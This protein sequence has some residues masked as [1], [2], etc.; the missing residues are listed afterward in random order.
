M[1]SLKHSVFWKLITLFIVITLPVLVIGITAMALSSKKLEKEIYQ[2]VQASADNFAAALDEE[3]EALFHSAYTIYSATKL[4]WYSLSDSL[5]SPYDREQNF[6]QIVTFITNLRNSNSCVRNIRVYISPLLRAANAEGTGMGSSSPISQEEFDH[7][8]S[9]LPDKNF[10]QY[11][12][13]RIFWLQTNAPRAPENIIEVE[14]DKNRLK[15][16]LQSSVA[17][18]ENYYALYTQ[19]KD[20]ALTNIEDP[21]LMEA[22]RLNDMPDPSLKPVR[23]NLSGK[24]YTVF[25]SHLD[26][27]DSTYI[28]AVPYTRLMYQ[29]RLTA[30]LTAGFLLAMFAGT[31]LFLSGVRFYVHKPLSNLISAFS[32]IGSGDLDVR[33]TETA[34]TE[35]SR[36]Y[37]EFN[38]M[39]SRLNTLI[40]Q[41]SQQKILLQ[42]AE[43]KQLQAQ[44][45]PHFLYNSFFMLQRTI[46]YD[47]REEAEMLAEELG[48]YF[49][50]VTRDKQDTVLL[51]QEY[52][53]AR[54]YCHIQQ[55]RFAGRID[56]TLQALP[57]AFLNLPV[58]KFILQPILE[59]S[60]THGLE[61]KMSDGLLV[62]SFQALGNRLV[63][64]IED[65]GEELTEDRL[66]MMQRKIEHCGMN[67]SGQEITGILNVYKRLAFYSQ[68]AGVLRLSRSEL[69]GLH[70]EIILYS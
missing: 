62:I 6:N 30:I 11:E 64:H 12:D 2:S 38:H 67:Y 56:I 66:K 3:M 28:Q 53:H 60:F 58:P 8:A 26:F 37:K 41:G 22:I 15:R 18:S 4:D 65:N 31:L 48:M 45:N 44:I 40:E 42:K 51:S 20:F 46:Q 59:N 50:Y 27:L 21:E 29:S 63:I 49:R 25:Y 7:A 32:R 69:G 16:R 70:T 55:L 23:I 52:E 43:M 19:S 35:F 13:S 14:L 33:I 9:L 5:M 68:N 34:N 39:A 10:L 1:I 61:N 24:Y 54:I 47:D 36:L 57:E 17:S